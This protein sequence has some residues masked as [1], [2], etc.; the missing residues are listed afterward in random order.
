[1]RFLSVFYTGGISGKITGL[2]PEND[3]R[4]TLEFLTKGYG[5]PKLLFP[6]EMMVSTRDSSLPQL[7]GDRLPCL[8]EANNKTPLVAE[9][10]TCNY[11][12]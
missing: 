5:L 1:M 7:L 9:V 10:F 4:A 12:R 2:I 3:N 8:M 11:Y 6:S